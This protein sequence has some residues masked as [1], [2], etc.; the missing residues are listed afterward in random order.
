[1]FIYL[2]GVSFIIFLI[3]NR[4]S[5]IQN[6]MRKELK[7]MHEDNTSLASEIIRG[8]RDLKVLN[9]KKNILDKMLKI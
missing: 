5:K 8:I 3:R 4:R 7:L 9:A 6:K 1:M 2:F